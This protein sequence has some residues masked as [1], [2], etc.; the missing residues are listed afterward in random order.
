VKTPKPP[1]LPLSLCPDFL[2]WVFQIASPSRFLAES[3]CPKS[4][5]SAQYFT[6][7]RKYEIAMIEYKI[8]N[9]TCSREEWR[10]YRKILYYQKQK[11]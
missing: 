10:A 9:R 4:E 5:A 8:A 6:N 7:L 3:Y 2:H 11:G 1:R